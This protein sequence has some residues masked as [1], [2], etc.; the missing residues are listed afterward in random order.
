[1]ERATKDVPARTTLETF[2]PIVPREENVGGLLEKVKRTIRE[3]IRS[4]P[5][6][7]IIGG[8]KV[9]PPESKLWKDKLGDVL[10]PDKQPVKAAALVTPELSDLSRILEELGATEIEGD[11][12]VRLLRYCRNESLE[13]CIASFQVL[14]EGGL[15][16]IPYGVREREQTFNLLREV[17]CWW[18]DN[19]QARS[20]DG[21]CP[22]LWDKPKDWPKW[23]T[24]DSLH[25]ES[26]KK[27]G[28]WEKERKENDRLNQPWKD[29]T[30]DFLLREKTHYLDRV[31][32]PVVEKWTIQE[33]KR[34][35]F[36]VLELLA[37]WESQHKFD[38]TE[39]CIKGE[40]GRRNTLA[41]VLHLPTDKGWLPAIDCFAGKNWD[42]PE[43]FDEFFKNAK[44]SGVV[45]SFQEWPDDLQE[46]GKD[47]WEDLL[48]WIG[49]SWEPKVCQTQDFTISSHRLWA[50][51]RSGRKG[52]PRTVKGE[53]IISF[54]IFQIVNPRL[55]RRISY[56]P[57]LL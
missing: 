20:L 5:F 46:V 44:G 3:K 41:T 17:P 52:R 4:A 6:V 34:R 33:W 2:G 35:G 53:E 57:F 1:M 56:S 28:E 15:K 32:I 29:L 48:R 43:A 12:Y 50:V 16:Q 54:G 11:E 39:P 47:K 45:Q 14:T 9:A 21:E 31:L 36:D 42:G 19:E 26:R 37:R 22:L 24:A 8:G 55:E 23:L 13:D 30:N 7:P 25:P 51:Y 18:T 10:R 38:Q 27:I 40:E 49:V